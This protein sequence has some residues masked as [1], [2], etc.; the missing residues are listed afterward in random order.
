MS[1]RRR[2]SATCHAR[3]GSECVPGPISTATRKSCGGVVVGG[4]GQR[5]HGG[6][7]KRSRTRR[8]GDV[9]HDGDCPTTLD[10]RRTAIRRSFVVERGTAVSD[11]AARRWSWRP[12]LPTPTATAVS[13]LHWH[14]DRDAQIL[15]FAQDDRA[16]NQDDRADAQNGSP[17]D[18]NDMGLLA[19]CSDGGHEATCSDGGHEA[20]CSDGG[21][22]VA[23]SA[24]GHKKK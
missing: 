23:G 22:G 10:G 2:I 4:E 14:G 3:C 13:T 6:R 5:R 24:Y 19:T 11:A 17:G 21:R 7:G 8:S 12:S 9:S 15:R 18:Q 16:G 20:T 1:W